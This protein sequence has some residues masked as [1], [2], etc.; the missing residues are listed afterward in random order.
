MGRHFAEAELC[1]QGGVEADHRDASRPRTAGSGG[2]PSR[3]ASSC[4]TADSS[5]PES[6]LGPFEAGAGGVADQAFADDQSLGG[7]VPVA[8]VEALGG[9]RDGGSG[10][11]NVT[12]AAPAR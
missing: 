6:R 7:Q 9:G 2:S 8:G 5:S 3:V 11:A 10:D 12:A 1:H 4:M